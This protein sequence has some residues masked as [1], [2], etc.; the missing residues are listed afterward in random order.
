MDLEGLKAWRAGRT[1]GYAALDRACTR[2]GT[3]DPFVDALSR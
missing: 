3:I 2:F 1:S